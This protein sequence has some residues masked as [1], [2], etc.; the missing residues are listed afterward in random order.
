MN[1]EVQKFSQKIAMERRVKDTR[2]WVGTVLYGFLAFRCKITGYQR[3][4][5]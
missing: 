3:I 5:T 4:Y 2:L 1:K